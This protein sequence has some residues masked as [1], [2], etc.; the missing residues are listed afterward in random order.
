MIAQQPYWLFS[1]HDY[2][3]STKWSMGI[4]ARTFWGPSVLPPLSSLNA[5]FAS[6]EEIIKRGVVY[7][8]PPFQLGL[9]MDAW[10][11]Q[12]LGIGVEVFYDI[13][14]DVDI[15]V[16]SQSLRVSMPRRK[17]M[18]EVG[19]RF[20]FNSN[21]KLG[22]VW[23]KPGFTAGT[24]IRSEGHSF[25]MYQNISDPY[26]NWRSV[27][28]KAYGPGFGLVALFKASF[29]GA[30]LELLLLAFPTATYTH[31]L[32]LE[33]MVQY[34]RQEPMNYGIT[35]EDNYEYESSWLI[36]DASWW[37]YSVGLNYRFGW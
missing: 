18:E 10:F 34:F 33:L 21:V 30:R 1:G 6:S 19:L 25:H 28:T 3:P 35:Y 13:Q 22:N 9:Q 12:W 5:N 14:E 23:L 26:I 4:S 20:S 31:T 2:Q 7:P 17:S 37:N 16:P 29:V 15:Y 36:S 24:L 11:N 32:S 27:H 8:A